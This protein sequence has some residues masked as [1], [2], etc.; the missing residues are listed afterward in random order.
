M[1]KE[2]LLL[3]LTDNEVI[4]YEMLHALPLRDRSFSLKKGIESVQTEL[5]SM[6]SAT[7]HIPVRLYIHRNQQDVR[8][9][10]IPALFLWDRIRFIT[11][12]RE[13][14]I[15]QG[16]FY[17]YHIF[18]QEGKSYLQW[19][20]ISQ[21]D[22]LNSWIL[23]ILSLSNPIEGIF[24]ISLEAGKFL[25][26]Y[27]SSISDYL[28]LIYKMNSHNIHHVIFKG[29][30]LLLFRPLA[31]EEDL[32]SSLHFLSRTYQDIHE[33]LHI[34]NLCKEF[35]V[36]IPHITTLPDPQ[37]LIRFLSLQKRPSLS[38]NAYPLSHP[39]WI[40]RGCAALL[41]SCFFVIGLLIYSGLSYKKDNKILLS[42]IQKI[43]SK[44]DNNKNLLKTRDASK[45]RSALAHYNY[46]K[47]HK[48]NPLKEFEKLSIALRKYNIRLE[49][50]IWTYDGSEN[51]EISFDIPEYKK[52]IL[53]EK[54]NEILFS[55]K[56]LFPDAHIQIIEG[57]FKS[58]TH[59]TYTYPLERSSP[60]VQL[61]IM[62][63]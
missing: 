27:F 54:F 49:N 51:L 12:K 33:K 63:P 41:I 36:N 43:K 16:R 34:L 37:E 1:M 15:S 46:I 4:L 44:I 26:K 57:P 2:K 11:H 13:A 19:S 53:E 55:L 35:S 42:E 47:S 14:W 31:R 5:Q 56:H 59:E 24:F 10:Q 6:L 61:R 32:R 21:N 23:W 3:V 30:R 58:S 8:E 50:L 18:K 7:P 38:F 62:L 9:E 52:I 60:C 17:G 45:L 39:L 29:K 28:V 22:S 48:R 40:K 20:N 25:K